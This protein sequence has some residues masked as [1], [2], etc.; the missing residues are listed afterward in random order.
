MLHNNLDSICEIYDYK[1]FAK[2]DIPKNFIIEQK[3][4]SCYR[5]QELVVNP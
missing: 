5:S 1:D 2:V 3:A 4:E